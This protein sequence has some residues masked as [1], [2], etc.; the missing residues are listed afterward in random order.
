[1]MTSVVCFEGSYHLLCCGNIIR[2]WRRGCNRK[3]M[4]ALAG[5]RVLHY[6][7]QNAPNLALSIAAESLDMRWC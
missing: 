2:R 6:G 1:M 7:T 5:G 3:S 4:D